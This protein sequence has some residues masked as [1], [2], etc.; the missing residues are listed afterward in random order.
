MKENVDEILKAEIPQQE[1]AKFSGGIFFALF[2]CTFV[3]T[4]N[5]FETQL[6]MC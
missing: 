3:L 4:N 5:C 2:K 1:P 6:D